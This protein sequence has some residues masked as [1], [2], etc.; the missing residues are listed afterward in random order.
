MTFQS[1]EYIIATQVAVL[2]IQG[3]GEE[4]KVLQRPNLIWL[5]N[6]ISK[7]LGECKIQDAHVRYILLLSFFLLLTIIKRETTTAAVLDKAFSSSNIWKVIMR[8]KKWKQISYFVFLYQ[9]VLLQPIKAYPP[10]H[11]LSGL[12]PK[13]PWRWLTFWVIRKTSTY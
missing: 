11:I 2:Y 1:K 12:T 9:M 13:E 6:W 4:K 3:I 8:Q 5:R 10:L 7:R